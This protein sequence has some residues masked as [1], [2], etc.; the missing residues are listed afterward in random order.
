MTLL[1][2][3]TLGRKFPSLL[4]IDDTW[5]PHSLVLQSCTHPLTAMG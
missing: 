5:S 4:L 3:H 2:G 1:G